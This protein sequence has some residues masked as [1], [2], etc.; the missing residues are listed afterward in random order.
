MRIPQPEEIKALADQLGLAVSDDEVTA[1]SEGWQLWGSVLESLG[2]LEAD[3]P[4]VRQTIRDPGYKPGP[5]EDPYNAFL[6]KCLVKGAPEGPLK[7]K[8]VAVKDNVSV[9]GV[10]M[11]LASKL[12]EGFIPDVDATII[13]RLLDAGADIV[14]KLNMDNFSHGSHG[15]GTGIGD[16]PRVKNPHNPDH[17]TGGSSSGSGAAVAAG[18]VD[19]AIGGDQGGSIR[20]PAAWCGVVG[21]KP[22]HGLIP[23]TGII[24]HDPLIDYTGP[25]ARRVE[26]VALATQV[27]AGP[28]GFDPRQKNVPELENY[29]DMLSEDLTGMRIGV[30][31]EGFD[32]DVL[33]PDV[34]EAVR[35]AIKVL[36]KR[37]A[38]VREVSVP[39]HVTY[40]RLPMIVVFLGSAINI[41]TAGSVVAQGY[42]QTQFTEVFGKF[43]ESRSDLLPPR[44]KFA[45]L[46]GSHLGYELYKYYGQV[47]NA[48]RKLS[49]IYDRVFEELDCL[50]MPTVPFKA[51]R[52]EEPKDRLEALRRAVARRHAVPVIRNTGMF[53]V[54]GHPAISVPCGLRQGLPV[55]MMLVGPKF[56]DGLLFKAAYAYQQSV[57]WDSYFL[58]INYKDCLKGVDSGL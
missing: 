27:M 19:I 1:I 16:V 34:D 49:Q 20:I 25:M 17:V 39:E 12:M 46:L 22:T 4:P 40:S 56:G 38:T 44:M 13:T 6:Q 36:E 54:S 29:M 35:E 15:F 55:G 43:L 45:M 18:M 7:G 28:D 14:G 58:P 31:K 9:A 51:P 41:A 52:Y 47:Q 24:G 23:H 42:H 53:N 11:T 26:D 8:T 33:E 32:S 5:D 48:A 21:H 57:D 10:P 37:G 2:D 30:L 50:V 3:L